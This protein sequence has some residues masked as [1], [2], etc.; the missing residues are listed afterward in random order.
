MPDFFT[1]PKNE[2]LA[3]AAGI[4]ENNAVTHSAQ[5]VISGYNK[6]LARAM[7]FAYVDGLSVE[8]ALQTTAGEFN[9]RNGN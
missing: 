3:V 5:Y 6:D 7:Q 4:L 2:F 1:Q 9:E 8:D